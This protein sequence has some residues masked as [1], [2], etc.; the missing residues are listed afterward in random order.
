MSY[1]CP[2]CSGRYT[3]SVSMMYSEHTRRWSGGR[4]RG[5]SSQTDLA[6]EHSPPQSRS[7][8][9]RTILVVLLCVVLFQCLSVF[10][11]NAAN[12]QKPQPAQT[13]VQAQEKPVA[14]SR[15]RAHKGRQKVAAVE[16]SIAPAGVEPQP[17]P[18][19]VKA[20]IHRLLPI[21]GLACLAIV[22]LLVLLSLSI[23]KTKRYNTSVWGPAMQLWNASFLC[24]ACGHVF[25]PENEP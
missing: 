16:P 21:L 6:A 4:G 17:D 25:I 20:A 8:V 2:Q 19:A 11:L 3:Q 18:Q 10:S 7:T 24:K 14:P 5:G 23:G 13:V 1:P 15:G 9:G 12:L 22:A